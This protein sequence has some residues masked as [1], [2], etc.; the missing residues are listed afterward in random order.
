MRQGIRKHFFNENYFEVIDSEDKAYWLGFISADG[1][2]TKSSKYNSY[3]LQIAISSIDSDHLNK[4]LRCVG[5]NDINIKI[6]EPAG[7]ANGVKDRKIARVT[8]NSYKL[9]NDLH[10]LNIHQNKS[11]DITMPTLSN[12]M[13]PHYLRGFFDGD[14]SYYY[15]YDAKN[16]RYRYSFEVVSASEVIIRQI[17]EY[18]LSNGINTNIYTR[19]SPSSNNY[20]FRLMT[21]SKKEMLKI[22]DLLYSDAHIYLDRK[23]NKTNEIKNIAV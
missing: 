6:L 19:K 13:I 12:E 7:F 8:L 11:Y 17:K 4:F 5:A 1:C 3:R 10:K 20:V 16:R 23:Y 15:H 18:L 14:G 2:V 21:G 9:C 22:I